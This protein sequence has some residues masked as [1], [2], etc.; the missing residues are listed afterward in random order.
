MALVQSSVS[1]S[2][3]LDLKGDLSQVELICV[4]G[5]GDGAVY[6]QLR[7]WLQKQEQR[8]I[9]FIEDDEEHFLKMKDASWAKDPKVRIFF[10]QEGDEELF[11]EIAWEF[12]FLKFG[13]FAQADYVEK[14]GEKMVEIFSKMEHYH[15]GID[16]VASDFQDMGVAVLK[17]VMENQKKLASSLLGQSLEGMCRQVPAIICGAG[18]SLNVQI[19]LLASLQDRAM[20]FAG[21]SAV[22]ALTKQGVSPHFCAHFDPN[23]PRDRFLQQDAAEI[24]HFYQSRFSSSLLNL[25]H[26][27]LLWMAEGGNYPIEK[28]LKE[29]Y[30]I[31]YAT[32]DS[33]W[34]VANFCTAAA[35]LLGCSPIIFVGMEFSCQSD[36]VYAAGMRADE[37]KEE[38]VEVQNAEGAK[39]FTK[40]DWMMSAEWQAA[41]A[42]QHPGIRFVNATPHGL[43]ILNT[44]TISLNEAANAYLQRQHDLSGAVHALMQRAEGLQLQE[45]AGQE[46]LEMLIQS[47]KQCDK[48]CDALLK[49]WEKHYPKSPMEKGEYAAAEHDLEKEVAF[50]T[51]LE[52][53]WQIWKRP[54]L[55]ASNHP[56][57]NHVHRLLFFKRAIEA[58]LRAI[59]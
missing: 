39:L 58:N 16:L 19:P 57:G 52:P 24:P 43:A 3:L 55:R 51:I 23:P 47:Y 12:L 14:K 56:L 48:V 20:I 25:V 4:Y 45:A 11:K 21:G 38:F 33:G 27:P 5:I 32:F 36:Q 2:A 10:Y 28:W 29:R 18:P 37:H 40:N 41:L 59:S 22:A 46:T 8:F 17:N 42:A 44:E 53:L 9:L 7:S 13:F 50:Q 6:R 49:L 34:T 15:R 1:S 30:S 26:G 54:I 31:P 35:V